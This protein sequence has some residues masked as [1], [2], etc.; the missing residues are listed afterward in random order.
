MEKQVQKGP[1]L[2]LRTKFHRLDGHFPPL[3]AFRPLLAPF[4]TMFLP[5]L[6]DSRQCPK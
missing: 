5:A 3:T 6:F 1:L 2:Q 4:R